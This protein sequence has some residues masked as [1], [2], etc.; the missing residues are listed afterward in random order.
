MKLLVMSMVVQS[1]SLTLATLLTACA[2][3][4]TALASLEAAIRSIVAF[5]KFGSGHQGLQFIR[6]RYG[7]WL[8]LVL[9]FLIAGDILRTAVE[10]SWTQLGQL[11]AIVVLRTVITITL[12]RE[13]SAEAP[14]EDR[15]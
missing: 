4:L 12:S 2:V 15:A 5:G 14:G 9:D 13:I 6:W 10:P 3:V 1:W 8:T 11:G 7:R